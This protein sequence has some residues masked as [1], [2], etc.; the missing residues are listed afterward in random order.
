MPGGGDAEGAGT[1]RGV[2]HLKV[3]EPRTALAVGR[4]HQDE[5][6]LGGAV[7]G[8]RGQLEAGRGQLGVAVGPADGEVGR[9]RHRGQGRAP[10]GGGLQAQGDAQ[11][12]RGHV[13]RHRVLGREGVAVGG[14][15]EGGLGAGD[16]V[17]DHRGDRRVVDLG[18]DVVALPCRDQGPQGGGLAVGE[19]AVGV[20]GGHDGTEA[21]HLDDAGG[22]ARVLVGHQHGA[23]R[24][25]P[26]V[27][28]GDL[29]VEG[30]GLVGDPGR[31]HRHA[32][33]LLLDVL[34]R[35]QGEGVTVGGLEHH[36]PALAG[37]PGEDVHP[38]ERRVHRE[39]DRSLVTGV[40]DAGGGSGRLPG[41]GAPADPGRDEVEGAEQLVGVGGRQVGTGQVGVGV[42][43]GALLA[44]ARGDGLDEAPGPLTQALGERHGDDGD[45]VGPHLVG[46]ATLLAQGAHAGAGRLGRRVLAVEHDPGRVVLGRAEL[47]LLLRGGA[48]PE[49]EVA[50]GEQQDGLAHL[51][52][53]ALADLGR[54]LGEGLAGAVE[55]VVEVRVHAGVAVGQVG[56]GL[57]D[58]GEG[59]GVEHGPVADR[60]EVVGEG[61][62][63][64]V[65][66]GLTAG[67]G[68]PQAVQARQGG[69]GRGHPLV[70]GV[71]LL[72]A[73]R[74]VDEQHHLEAAG[75][76]DAPG[77]AVE[78]VR[79]PLGRVGRGLAPVLGARAPA[80]VTTSRRG[81]DPE[82]HPEGEEDDGDEGSAQGGHE[83]TS[84]AMAHTWNPATTKARTSSTGTTRRTRGAGR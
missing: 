20:Q 71:G 46:H 3:L 54:A 33:D 12:G 70:V 23:P 52:A 32:V 10:G 1:A 28:G 48:G 82:A 25:R 60:G 65:D 66:L 2:E 44:P 79:H 78:R 16:R 50:V 26:H 77:Q 21:H 59:V 41:Q 39:G 34:A 36:A 37:H 27:A 61:R 81:A 4:L 14:Q 31:L 75:G 63:Q 8:D 11:G 13:G 51:S 49:A 9:R 19:A 40:V 45:A 35:L 7:G 84:V 47:L 73:G 83:A 57:V 18:V 56:D 64:H 5:G 6:P 17:G 29:E 24:A 30:H 22:V 55:G 43:A 76:P 58:V 42:A 38:A 68:P 53:A 72:E 80:G 62:H 67:A 15:V 69:P 74:L